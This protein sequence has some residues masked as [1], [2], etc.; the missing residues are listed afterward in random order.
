MVMLATL[1]HDQIREFLESLAGSA[2]C[3][4]DEAGGKIRWSCAGGTDQSRARAILSRMGIADDVAERFLAQCADLGGH[5]DCEI[6]MN[7]ADA[8]VA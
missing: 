1:T 8:L 2:G 6:L 3:D 5:C 7:A 4:F